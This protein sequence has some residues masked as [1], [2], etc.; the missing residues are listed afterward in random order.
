MKIKFSKYKVV[1]FLFILVAVLTP[2][3][4][5]G[6]NTYNYNKYFNNGQNLLVNEEYDNAISSFKKS[7]EYN[8][9][10]SKEIESKILLAQSLKKSKGSFQ[11]ATEELKNKKYLES[12]SSLKKVI[13]EDEKRY[14]TSVSKIKEIEK[15]YINENT[16]NAK[17]EAENSKYDQAIVYLDK[18]LSYDNSNAEAK[19][20]KDK[21]NAAQEKLK[22]E[23]NAAVASQKSSSGNL[24]VS[25]GKNKSS[26]NNIESTKKREVL[27][28]LD[29]VRKEAEEEFIRK[30][31]NIYEEFSSGDRSV[32]NGVSGY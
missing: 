29:G 14:N 5:Y 2:I 21:Y 22:E 16:N 32:V 9:N 6:Y 25:S 13:K 7:L 8:R 17:K 12:I 26:A 10:N 11:T 15:E 27:K 3:S 23:N 4:V 19:S 24:S 20:L 28:S 1:I 18:I 30:S 31:Q